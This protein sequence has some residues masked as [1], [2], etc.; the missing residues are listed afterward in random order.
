MKK[1]LISLILSAALIISGIPF[2]AMA[3][4]TAGA[5]NTI[6]YNLKL[7]D[8]KSAKGISDALADKIS[9][10]LVL[11]IDSPNAYVYGNIDRVDR[12]GGLK[13]LINGDQGQISSEELGLAPFVTDGRTLLPIRFVS[14]SIGWSVE[15]DEATASA[16]ITN[17]QRTVIFTENSPLALVDGE[18]KA[19]DVPP[20]NLSGRLFVP[21]R[22]LAEALDYNVF[23]DESGLVVMSPEPILDPEADADLIAELADSFKTYSSADVQHPFT[24]RY[25]QMLPYADRD[26]LRKFTLD[27]I[28]TALGNSLTLGEAEYINDLTNRLTAWKYLNSNMTAVQAETLRFASCFIKTGEDF[29][30]RRAIV[31]LYQQALKFKEVGKYYSSSSALHLQALFA[32][33]YY[34]PRSCVGAYDI[35]YYSDQ[36]DV[37]SAELGADVRGE[38]EGWFGE[39][40]DYY[41]KDFGNTYI[42]N[43]N[44]DGLIGAM[45]AAMIINDPER[46]HEI[47]YQ[48]ESLLFSGYEFTAD[49]V[50]HEGTVNYQSDTMG[51]H[52]ENLPL[53]IYWAD[54]FGYVDTKYGF[55]LHYQSGGE[56]FPMFEE[57]RRFSGLMRY[58]NGDRVIIQ[59]T[60]P[61]VNKD[62]DK[63]IQEQYLRNV[64][65]YHFGHF[66]M[67]H[68]DTEDAQ[69][70]H[71]AFYPSAEG[72][73]YSS[74]HHYHYA[75]LP[76]MLWGGGMEVLPDIGYVN[77]T[78]MIQN[79][80]REDPNF[81]N[82]GYI[83]TN[84]YNPY[85][86][87]AMAA[88]RSLLAYDDGETSGK[89][90]QLIEASATGTDNPKNKTEVHR[91]LLLMVETRGNRSYTLDLQR[92]RGGDAHENFLISGEDERTALKYSLETT[93]HEGNLKELL[94]DNNAGFATNREY[95]TNPMSA[96]GS[97]DF[98]F[99]WKGEDSG[100]TLNVHMNGIEGSE[101]YF[102][103]YPS[104]REAH[105]KPAQE[106]D[107]PGWHFYRRTMVTQSDT[108][109]YGA[110]YE[111]SKKDREPLV[112]SVTW[113]DAPDGDPMTQAAVIDL[114]DTEDIVYI[115]DDLKE[116]T[117]E[118]IDFAGSVAVVRRNK[119]T[120]DVIWS[121][122]YGEGSAASGGYTHKGSEDMNFRVIDA[123][124]E[125][126]DEV[127]YI[128][129]QGKVETRDV[130]DKWMF[131]KFPDSTGWGLKIKSYDQSY[132][133][134]YQ[135]PAFE[136][137]D[138]GSKMLY[139]PRIQEIQDNKVRI[140]PTDLSGMPMKLRD[141]EQRG[142]E[143]DT[144]VRITLPAF[145]EN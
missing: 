117:I 83:W 3:E 53:F 24:Y 32:Q 136:V 4:D 134:T 81:H 36:W 44:G 48:M 43:T 17:G 86:D 121:Y 97:R 55:S 108:T 142:Y 100:T 8:V 23:W 135:P 12:Q 75:N 107:F 30:A 105:Q 101:V 52:I 56:I 78:T 68:G 1:R 63:E 127:K 102:S 50:W 61:T 25:V 18:Q 45:A 35:L 87:R 21:F 125:L 137:T 91:R 10:A 67:T 65:L 82:A 80:M 128:K 143:D 27:E 46:L 58:P 131:I 62:P 84:G 140:G 120:G 145:K 73:A 26:I 51:M 7:R 89:K 77:P 109:R 71:L 66:A 114:G 116:R 112:N 47:F 130:L 57:A 79:S 31:S 94:K 22:F 11:M 19:M 111:T 72:G 60:Y 6:T 129:V 40:I 64:E 15:W 90:V 144:W 103:N 34:I 54:P 9:G 138:G 85:E 76:I 20:H 38:V 29:Y 133:Y 59:D 2:S 98:N 139:F 49:G 141:L 69:Q 126:G 92:M 104:Y 96:N 115:S 42:Q 16:A 93:Q 118:G 37:L 113:L 74:R 122:I 70:V 5:E 39:I 41:L 124:G 28:K 110:V 13:S 95:L 106:K 123:T 14:E 99:S 119:A 88:R 33:M 132:I